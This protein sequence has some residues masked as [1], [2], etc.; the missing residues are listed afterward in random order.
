LGLATT[1]TNGSFVVRFL[2]RL[3]RNYHVE[4]TPDLSLWTKIPGSD[5]IGNGAESEVTDTNSLQQKR[6]FYR[7]QITV[8]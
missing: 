3:G 6:R 7:V 4:A 1:S 8:P 2:T 5:R